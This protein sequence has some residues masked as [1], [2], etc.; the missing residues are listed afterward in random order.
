MLALIKAGGV[1]AGLGARDIL[2]LEAGYPLHGHE[3]GPNITPLQA[4][5]DW[6][7]DWDKG[8]FCGRTALMKEKETGPKR[9]LWGFKIQNEK[10]PLRTGSQVH[11]EGKK[12]GELT[13]GNYSPTLKCA[14]GLG[15]IDAEYGSK[16][17]EV[18]IIQGENSRKAQ[19]CNSNFLKT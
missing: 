13:S 11:F 9:L 18:E 19:V 17:L 12:I 15:F 5:L 6:V 16:G 1:P 8:D 10:R 4:R 7:I 14:I 2:R 3:L